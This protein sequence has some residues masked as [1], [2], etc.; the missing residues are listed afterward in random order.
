VQQCAF[1]I[2]SGFHYV[3]QGGLH[4]PSVV[5]TGMHRYSQQ[6][7]VLSMSCGGGKT[8]TEPFASLN[9]DS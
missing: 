8:K 3:T 2:E 9:L 5:I 1:F 4:L 6:S 7:K